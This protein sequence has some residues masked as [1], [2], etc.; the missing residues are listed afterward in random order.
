[1]PDLDFSGVFVA[2]A[3]F[4][5]LAIAGVI[6]V[7]VSWLGHADA[8]LA[9]LGVGIVGGYAAGKFIRSCC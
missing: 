4:A 1:M 9:I 8:G 5:V 3:F 2:G 6:A 7:A